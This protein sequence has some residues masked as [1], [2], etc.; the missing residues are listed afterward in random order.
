[1]PAPLS[2][3]LRERILKAYK[4]GKTVKEIAASKISAKSTIY[5][6]IKLEKETG[7]V[8]PRENR[9]GRKPILTNDDLERIK[10]K[11]E[12]KSDIT[13]DELRNELNLPVCRSALC[14]T[15]NHKLNLKRKKDT[16]SKRTKSA[17]CKSKT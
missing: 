5:G 7:S 12:E 4:S 2:L 3:D 13:L 15:I 10:I 1:M 6:L 9:N 14:N 8:E 17:R 16:S 11:I